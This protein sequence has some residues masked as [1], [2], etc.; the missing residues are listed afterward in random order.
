PVYSQS[1]EKE[2]IKGYATGVFLVPQIIK[3][4]ITEQQSKMFSIAIYEDI[5]KPAFYSNSNNLNV[6]QGSKLISFNVDF[7]G[8]QWIV[9]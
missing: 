3:Q 9:K 1:N 4:A 6:A 8:Q 5:N 7:G 2:T